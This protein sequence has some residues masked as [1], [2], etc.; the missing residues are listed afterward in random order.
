MGPTEAPKRGVMEVMKSRKS[1]GQPKTKGDLGH[2]ILFKQTYKDIE[3]TYAPEADRTVARI[4]RE[5]FEFPLTR[6]VAKGVLAKIKEGE[7]VVKARG[8]FNPSWRQSRLT[9]WRTVTQS[10]TPKT[11]WRSATRHRRRTSAA[12]SREILGCMCSSRSRYATAPRVRRRGVSRN[13]ILK[14]L[15]TGEWGRDEIWYPDESRLDAQAKRFNPQN[16]RLYAGAGKRKE[17]PRRR[18]RSLPP[19]SGARPASCSK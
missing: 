16:G 11:R 12:S 18:R 13:E 6:G 1:K 15:E 14:K 5:G 7:S 10:P 3:P 2:I 19:R 9:V 4:Q 17:T 8:L